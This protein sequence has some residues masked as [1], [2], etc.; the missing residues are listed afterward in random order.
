MIFLPLSWLYCGYLIGGATKAYLSKKTNI[1]GK[2][3]DRESALTIYKM[4]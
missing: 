1:D 2:V 4:N 3:K